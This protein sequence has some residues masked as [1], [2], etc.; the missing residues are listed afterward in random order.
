MA[1]V[2]ALALDWGALCRGTLRNGPSTAPGLAD[3]PET[4]RVA[5]PLEPAEVTARAQAGGGDNVQARTRRI[6]NGTRARSGGMAAVNR[7][8]GG[9]TWGRNPLA[10]SGVPVGPVCGVRAKVRHQCRATRASAVGP[11][12]RPV[13]QPA[14]AVA[15]NVI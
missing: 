14:H 10:T 1:I 3:E 15:E 6:C 4:A 7:R 8:C 11:V 9:S 2:L 12:F 5:D 13:I